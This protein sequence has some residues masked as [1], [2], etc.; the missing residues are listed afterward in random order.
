VTLLGMGT[1]SA[2]GQGTV[3]FN[4]LGTGGGQS[5]I[6]H[7]QTLDTAG[8]RSPALFMNFGFATDET[9]SAGAF[10][11][12]LTVTISDGRS[13]FAVL[14]TMDAS[15]VLWAPT[16]P[17]ALPF[18]ESQ[19]QRQA[20]A[21]PASQPIL[22][23]GAAFAVQVAIPVQFQ[24]TAVTAQFDLFDNFDPRMSLGWYDNLQVISVPE[25]GA[26]VL[27]GFG[28]VVFGILQRRRT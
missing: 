23:R 18:S 24:S 21:P 20:I 19:I 28:M 11:D 2:S 22:G 25:P 8:V 27:L 10:L 26:G 12:S 3:N 13:T 7:Q 16:S 9:A 14:A 4:V 15:G 5:L 17:G 1:Y 6:T